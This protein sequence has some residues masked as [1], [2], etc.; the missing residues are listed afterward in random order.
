MHT[1]MF[2]HNTRPCAYVSFGISILCV[3]VSMV[4]LL[5]NLNP[6]M[7]DH[8]KFASGLVITFLTFSLM[9]MAHTWVSCIFI[10]IT[11]HMNAPSLPAGSYVCRRDQCI[12][13]RFL[14]FPNSTL[15]V[16]SILICIALDCIFGDVIL[17]P[18]SLRRHKHIYL[19][20]LGVWLCC[21]LRNI[22]W[23]YASCPCFLIS[24]T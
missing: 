12:V 22:Y 7:Y 1:W 20:D 5:L 23:C 24:G 21:V 10:V 15:H 17:A 19:C 8:L 14:L 2:C 3:W 11:I 9:W 18:F 13:W 6:Y 16:I 4:F